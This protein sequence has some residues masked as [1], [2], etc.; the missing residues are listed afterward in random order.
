[1]IFKGDSPLNPFKAVSAGSD[2]TKINREVL[3]Q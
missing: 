1:M 2:G 3:C